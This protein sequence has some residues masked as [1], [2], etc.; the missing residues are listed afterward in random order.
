[1]YEE[2]LTVL[3]E[4]KNIKNQEKHLRLKSNT[5]QCLKD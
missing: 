4:L 3:S 2:S 5:Y 1:M